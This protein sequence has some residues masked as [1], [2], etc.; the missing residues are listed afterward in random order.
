MV[1]FQT[2]SQNKKSKKTHPIIHVDSKCMLL[3]IWQR[4]CVY[5]SRVISVTF[6]LH[7]YWSFPLLRYVYFLLVC[8]L[9][10]LALQVIYA[11]LFSGLCDLWIKLAVNYITGVSKN[12]QGKGDKNQ[13]FNYYIHSITFQGLQDVFLKFYFPWSILILLHVF[14]FRSFLSSLSEKVTICSSWHFCLDMSYLLRYGSPQLT[15]RK[16]SQNY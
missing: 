7:F 1:I 4:V 11:F 16:K 10:N 9:R 15:K 12:E 8:F 13:A 5:T 14:H 2:W 6:S 3:Q